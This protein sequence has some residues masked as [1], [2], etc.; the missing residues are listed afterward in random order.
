M[1]CRRV[2]VE[3]PRVSTSGGQSDGMEVAAEVA[4]GSS[5]D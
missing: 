1:V 5:L 2:H 3:R 4:E